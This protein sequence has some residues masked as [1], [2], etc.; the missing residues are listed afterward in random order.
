MRK[1]R[2]KLAARPQAALAEIEAAVA[3]EA[4]E[5]RA[6]W[7]SLSP[8]EQRQF[9]SKMGRM[10]RLAWRR[11]ERI[12]YEMLAGV[13][14]AARRGEIDPLEH[15]EGFVNA[16]KKLRPG[17]SEADDHFRAA[18]LQQLVPLAEIATRKLTREAKSAA[19]RRTVATQR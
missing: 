12:P 6:W 11:P 14:R 2:V 19:P 18:T 10:M 3:A 13:T 1:R 4:A 17:R 8:A 9:V 16:L 5:E 15:L 7:A